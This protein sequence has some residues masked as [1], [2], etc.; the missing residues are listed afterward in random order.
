MS[1]VAA[2]LSRDELARMRHVDVFRQYSR[3]IAVEGDDGKEEGQASPVHV[4]PPVPEVPPVRPAPAAVQVA[5]P[6]GCGG[7]KFDCSIC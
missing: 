7:F 6:M 2:Q 5:P 4:T 1:V 3:M